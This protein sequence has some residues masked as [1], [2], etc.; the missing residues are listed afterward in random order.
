MSRSSTPYAS[1]A[2]W[3]APEGY[4]YAADV[5]VEGYYKTR[6]RAG[7]IF[8]GI[9]IWFGPPLDPVTGEEMDRSHRWQ[10]QANGRY[11]DLERVWPS[12]AR[13]TCTE[14]EYRYLT[15]LQDWGEANAPNS[16]QAKPTTP[17][18]LLTAPLPL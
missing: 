13:Q 2:A 1:G 14:A 7:G 4:G 9:R 5:P 15:S 12:C 18:D 11:I 10:A 17:V 8:V 6:L 16:P 3:K